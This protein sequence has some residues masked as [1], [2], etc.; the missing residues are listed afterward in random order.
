MKKYTIDAKN[1]KLGRLASE[2]AVLLMGKNLID[3]KKNKVSEVEVSVVN[4]SKMDLD[5]KKIKTKTYSSYS[6]YPGGL[7]KMKAERAIEK[8]GY[9]K[10]IENAIKRMLPNNRLR[11]IRLKAL[12]ISE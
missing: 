12:K 11:S 4:A 9:K 7:K 10:L 3:Y 1:K 6:G 2:L 5:V 8:G